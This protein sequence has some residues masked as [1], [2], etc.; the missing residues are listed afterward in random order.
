MLETKYAM[1]SATLMSAGSAERKNSNAYAVSMDKCE[2]NEKLVELNSSYRLHLSH[3]SSTLSNESDL[4]LS[5][6]SI[7]RELSLYSSRI[8]DSD[9][10]PAF[11][12]RLISPQGRTPS[13]IDSDMEFNTP[14]K[15]KIISKADVTSNFKQ[16]NP[17][18]VAL[19]D[20]NARITPPSDHEG[21]FNRS[22]SLETIFE[23]VFLNTPPKQRRSHNSRR[24]LLEKVAINRLHCGKENTTPPHRHEPIPKDILKPAKP[25]PPKDLHTEL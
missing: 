20:I 14:T 15:S 22:N 8:I 16:N 25:W 9:E 12:V 23:G 24:S 2:N 5:A 3:G 1:N 10:L 6:L 21:A 17:D 18:F 11:E 13:P 4:S 19:Q 7:D